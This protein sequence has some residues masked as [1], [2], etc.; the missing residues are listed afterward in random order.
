MAMAD[1]DNK[2]HNF[3]TSSKNA[4]DKLSAQFAAQSKA[5][6]AWAN[7]KIKG[8]VASTAAQFNDVNTKL[9]QNREEVDAA[10]KRATMRFEAALNAAQA[11]EDSRFAQTQADIAAAKKEA[12]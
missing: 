1:W 7:N 9:A 12:A 10:L 5:T 3:R 2:V 4:R 11:L 6:R 8:F